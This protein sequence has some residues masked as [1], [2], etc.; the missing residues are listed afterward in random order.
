MSHKQRQIGHIFIWLFFIIFRRTIS[1]RSG[2]HKLRNTLYQFQKEN[3][4]K[5]LQ[6][7]FESTQWYFDHFGETEFEGPQLSRIHVAE[8]TKKAGLASI[9]NFSHVCPGLEGGTRRAA[10]R[11]EGRVSPFSEG[12]QQLS[13]PYRNVHRVKEQSPQGAWIHTFVSTD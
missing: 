5:K 10:T 9:T 4:Q 12:C 7:E 8:A 13:F 2:S 11:N 1:S 3:F 6:D